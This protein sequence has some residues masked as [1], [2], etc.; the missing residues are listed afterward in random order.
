MH[1]VQRTNISSWH[2]D[3]TQS[4]TTTPSQSWQGKN[5]NEGV[6]HFLQSSRHRAL[7]SDRLGFIQDT[8]WSG[9]TLLLRCP[10]NN[11]FYLKALFFSCSNESFFGILVYFSWTF[12]FFFFTNTVQNTG[13]FSFPH[14]LTQIV[15]FCVSSLNNL[16]WLISRS[17]SFVDFKKG[18]V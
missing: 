17:S 13:V 16:P 1:I 12:F 8:H 6:L 5:G 7:R 11:Y 4:R 14:F 3:R 15:R 10:A 18:A 9:L 2:T